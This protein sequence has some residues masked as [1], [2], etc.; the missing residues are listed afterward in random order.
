MSIFDDRS[1]QVLQKSMDAASLRQNVIA[2]N[3]ANANTPGF[4]SSSV[5]FEDELRSSLDRLDTD[6]LKIWE[7]NDRHMSP[8][9]DFGDVVPAV[10]K[11][12]STTSRAD[13]NNVDIEEEMSKLAMNGINYNFA[14]QRAN[15]KL[16]MLRYII[17]E[18]RR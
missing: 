3:I 7:T 11:N 1:L 2:N 16:S 9:A 4:K 15:K 17:S 10:E 8:A 12:T 6:R 5:E 14:S 18:G 13:E